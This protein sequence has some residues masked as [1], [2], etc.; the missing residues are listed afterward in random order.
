MQDGASPG[1]SHRFPIVG[2]GASAGGLEAATIMFKELSPALG[3]AYVLVLHLDPARESAVT[4]IL[5]RATRMP[6]LQVKEGMRVEPD[7]VYVIPPNCEM[8]IA[9]WVLHL[10]SRQERRSANTTIDTFLRSLA[11]AHGSDAIG[12]ILSGTA[13]DGTHGL[14][15]DQGRSR[16]HLRPGADLSQIRRHA[17]ERDRVR[18]CRFRDDPRGA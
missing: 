17:G 6:V 4:E 16:D 11:M 1:R 13:S 2:I 8:T 14:A 9:E 12:V 3:M 5:A 15:A 7:H 18:L 10:G